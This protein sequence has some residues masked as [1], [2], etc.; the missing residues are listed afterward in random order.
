[1]RAYKNLTAILLDVS[2]I[3]INFILFQNNYVI[4]RTLWVFFYVY[5]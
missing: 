2:S 4:K 3:C 5:T 1:M